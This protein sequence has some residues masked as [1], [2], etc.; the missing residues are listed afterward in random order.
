M[1]LAFIQRAMSGVEK[2]EKAPH[3]S[4]EGSDRAFVMIRCNLF[5]VEV[6]FPVSSLRDDVVNRTEVAAVTCIAVEVAATSSGG[7]IVP[8]EAWMGDVAGETVGVEIVAEGQNPGQSIKYLH[9]L[10]T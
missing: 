2:Q 7:D 4:R 6:I 8:A 1:K 9:F 3:I 5:A 10:I